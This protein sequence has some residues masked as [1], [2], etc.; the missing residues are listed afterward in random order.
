MAARCIAGNNGIREFEDSFGAILLEPGETEPWVLLIRSAHGWSFPK[1][2]GEPGETP[3]E[4][5]VREIFEETGIRAE[6]DPGYAYSVPSAR[7][8]DC[9][10]ITFFA[11]ES[12]EGR[13]PPV[14][15]EVR[16]AEWV[17]LST[18]DGMV[19]FKPDHDTGTTC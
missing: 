19:N 6:V 11:G 12:L 7:K 9:R 18:A 5:A 3:E 15:D 17:P 8:G 4:T 1:G 16:G 10:T 2:H 13:K 14:A